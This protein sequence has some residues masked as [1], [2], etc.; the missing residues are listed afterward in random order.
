M[1]GQSAEERDYHLMYT[2]WEFKLHLS[3]IS[4]T[5]QWLELLE[6]LWFDS[7]NSWG[8]YLQ[9]RQEYWWQF[10]IP[11]GD[12]DNTRS[13]SDDYDMFRSGKRLGHAVFRSGKRHVAPETQVA[14]TLQWAQLPANDTSGE[15]HTGQ[16]L[17][18][19]LKSV[20]SLNYTSLLLSTQQ[21]RT[22]QGSC[23]RVPPLSFKPA[24]VYLRLFIF[25][26][27]NQIWYVFIFSWGKCLKAISSRQWMKG[28]EDMWAVLET[29][30]RIKVLTECRVVVREGTAWQTPL[31]F[32]AT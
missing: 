32:D 17:Q 11:R 14:R 23:Q 18:H 9:L 15:D 4:P 3:G 31:A 22:K 10:H 27:T 21:S 20:V 28:S 25:L 29:L 6:A 7:S 2:R 19:S 16:T 13:S 12:P 8:F 30:S 24:T 1:L 26:P 5:F